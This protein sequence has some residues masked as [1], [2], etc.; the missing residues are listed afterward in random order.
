[1]QDHPVEFNAASVTRAWDRAADAYAHGQSVGRDY[2]LG[3]GFRVCG[4]REP[5]PNERALV[6]R[7]DLEDATRMPYFLIFDLC[8]RSNLLIK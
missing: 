4:L 3:A 5:R 8:A 2:L 1:M 7:P 6:S